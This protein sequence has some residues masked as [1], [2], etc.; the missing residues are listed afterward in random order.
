VEGWIE[1]V[2]DA[3]KD[4]W[5]ATGK[6]LLLAHVPSQLRL[7][8]IEA[9]SFLGGRKLKEALEQDGIGTI[10]L[11]RDPN[12]ELVWG[13][14]PA[15][16]TADVN[17]DLFPHKASAGT[18]HDEIPQFA[19]GFWSA[20]VKPLESDKRRFLRA[21]GNFDNLPNDQMPPADGIEISD[22]YIRP[23]PGLG[24]DMHEAVME[25]ITKWAEAHQV[26]VS[27]YRR[28][29]GDRERT[30]PERPTGPTG[31][32]AGFD[33]LPDSDLQ[34]VLVPMDIVRKLLIKRR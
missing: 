19:R 15:E 34:R 29:I 30:Q 3:S 23:S 9:Q 28:Q 20:F 31:L 21:D 22:K 4:H 16:V 33:G 10:R 17:S 14:L 25:S 7:R 1:A 13:V 2:K 18:P 6:A 11:V 12:D 32:F 8:G 27:Q 5:A 24:E 26:D